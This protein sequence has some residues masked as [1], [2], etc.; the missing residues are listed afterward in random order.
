M[1]TVFSFLTTSSRFFFLFHTLVVKRG[2]RW[3]FS[4]DGSPLFH[5]FSYPLQLFSSFFWAA[6]KRKG[7][8]RRDPE[9]TLTF[10][11]LISRHSRYFLELA[12]LS[13]IFIFKRVR[14]R[15]RRAVEERNVRV[16]PL[17]FTS[18]FT[19]FFL[20]RVFYFLDIYVSSGSTEKG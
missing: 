11:F 8:K 16:S 19:S 6:G 4:P 15:N 17:R 9:E 10:T 12:I 20:S 1:F 3:I 7:K 18:F 14:E 2:K 13:L 5:S